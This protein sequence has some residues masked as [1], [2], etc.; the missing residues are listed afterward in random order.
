MAKV[1]SLIL[2][3]EGTNP[4]IILTKDHKTQSIALGGNTYE[5]SIKELGYNKKMYMPG[6][7]TATIQLRV[8]SSATWVAASK[9]FLEAFFRNKKVSLKYGDIEKKPTLSYFQHVCHTE[10]LQS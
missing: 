6:E 3:I 10:Y 8:T 5:L 9:I 4:D 2:T 1:T 7:I